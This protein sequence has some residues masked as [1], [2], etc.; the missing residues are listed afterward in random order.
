MGKWCERSQ[1]LCGQGYFD[2]VCC[3]KKRSIPERETCWITIYGYRAASME[4][5]VAVYKLSNSF[6]RSFRDV[7]GSEIEEQ[8]KNKEQL[9]GT[10]RC[11]INRELA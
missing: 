10:S 6:E 7:F 1:R 3:F 4:I 5:E 2:I 8:P 11:C 9:E